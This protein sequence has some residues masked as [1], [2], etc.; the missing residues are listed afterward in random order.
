MGLRDYLAARADA[1]HF[2][3]ERSREESEIDTKRAFEVAEVRA[4]RAGRRGARQCGDVDY[5]G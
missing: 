2:A 4:I 3:S 5:F 1:Q